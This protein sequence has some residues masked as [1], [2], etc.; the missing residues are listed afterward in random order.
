MEIIKPLSSIFGFLGKTFFE[1]KSL[2]KK[3][4][5][6]SYNLLKASIQPFDEVRFFFREWDFRG[7]FSSSFLISF[8]EGVERFTDNP[9]NHFHDQDLQKHIMEVLETTSSMVDLALKKCRKTNSDEYDFEIK[10]RKYGDTE[11][12]LETGDKLNELS[13]QIFQKYSTFLELA[14]KRLIAT[15]EPKGLS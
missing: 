1:K 8:Y 9:E 15:N 4:D 10:C 12:D 11:D 13:T 2:E 3:S 14:K 7:A 5:L 6:E